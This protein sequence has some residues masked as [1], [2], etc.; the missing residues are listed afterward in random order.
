M[1]LYSYDTSASGY[2]GMWSIDGGDSITDNFLGN[3]SSYPQGGDATLPTQGVP[4]YFAIG[5]DQIL[6]MT[7]GNA[8]ASYDSTADQSASNGTWNHAALP[9]GLGWVG[10]S[11][12]SYGQEY[13]A[14]SIVKSG[15]NSSGN[16]QFLGPQ[17]SGDARVVLWNGADLD[18]SQLYYLDDWY[19]SALKEA[20][21]V[22]YAFTEGK[23]GTTK[24]KA[25]QPWPPYFQT[26]WEAPTSIVGH[27][28]NQNQIELFNEMICWVS[29]LIG[30]V[31][32]N[33]AVNVYGLQQTRLDFLCIPRIFSTM[34][35]TTWVARPDFL[36]TPRGISYSS[37]IT[38]QGTDWQDLSGMGNQM[39]L[40]F[41]ARSQI[42]L[43]TR[44]F[45]R[46]FRI[47]DTVVQS[48]V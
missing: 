36:K 11:V 9:F 33:G 42:T 18:F 41:L 22:L 4:K 39:D 24:V 3:N 29:P 10:T 25:L 30:G 23:N 37:D 26:V 27:A 6:Y 34:G 46:L 21:G 32:I 17:E 38:V 1:V 31:F 5:P 15:T 47:T 43:P 35:Q 16:T 7:N 19:C 14:V 28:P 2:V 45:G 40:P 20:N 8:L 44:S 12:C 13:V 48:S